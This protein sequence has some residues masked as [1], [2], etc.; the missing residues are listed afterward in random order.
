[1]ETLLVFVAISVERDEGYTGLRIDP[2]IDDLAEVFRRDVFELDDVARRRWRGLLGRGPPSA[3]RAQ[4][5]EQ[6][7]RDGTATVTTR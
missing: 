1:M 7:A 3:A 6:A 4:D 2:R 5:R